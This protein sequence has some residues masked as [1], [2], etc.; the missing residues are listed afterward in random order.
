MLTANSLA[1]VSAFIS[2]LAEF[3][4]IERLMRPRFPEAWH[5]NSQINL[6]MK[7]W[8]RLERVNT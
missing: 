7:I 2:W 8:E 5:T 4:P 6:S 1:G 3:L